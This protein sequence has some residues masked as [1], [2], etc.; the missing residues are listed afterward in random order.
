MKKHFKNLPDITIQKLNEIVLKEQRYRPRLRA[1]SLLFS[2][3]GLSAIQIAEIMGFNLDKLYRW[4][5]LFEKGGID[6]LYD[7][8]GKGAKKKIK[9]EDEEIIKKAFEN[10]LTLNGVMAEIDG[11]TTVAFSRQTLQRHCKLMKYTYKRLR[12]SPPKEPDE[13]LYAEKKTNS[14]V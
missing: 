7:K 8:E 13:T 5:R 10:Q 2:H 9:A 3:K 1:Q 4:W 14:K 12:F 6:A 11:K